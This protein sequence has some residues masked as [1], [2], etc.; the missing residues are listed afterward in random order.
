MARRVLALIIIEGTDDEWFR[1]NQHVR[2]VYEIERTFDSNNTAD[3]FNV[4]HVHW[5]DECRVEVDMT[6]QLDPSGDV[7]IEVTARF[8]E[9]DSI[10]TSDLADRD[11]RNFSVPRGGRPVSRE[12]DLHNRELGGGDLAKVKLVLTNSSVED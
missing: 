4:P 9:G 12:I 7:K 8:Y 11:R 5:G 2:E 6:G 1:A 10:Y 3:D